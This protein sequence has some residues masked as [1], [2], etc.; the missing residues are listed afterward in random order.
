MVTDHIYNNLV[1]KGKKNFI[2]GRFLHGL[3]RKEAECWKK[4][5]EK[6]RKDSMG[7]SSRKPH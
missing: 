7:L 5:E 2:I 4:K 3:G 1:R 6:G